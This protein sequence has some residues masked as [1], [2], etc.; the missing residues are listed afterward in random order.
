[1][2]NLNIAIDVFGKF[3]ALIGNTDK[4]IVGTLENASQVHRCMVEFNSK[5]ENHDDAI[6]DHYNNQISVKIL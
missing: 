3:H 6:M 4:C 5:L 2:E 1:M